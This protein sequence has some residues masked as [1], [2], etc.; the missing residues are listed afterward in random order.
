MKDCTHCNCSSNMQP[1][2]IQHSRLMDTA[3]ADDVFHCRLAPQTQKL[4]YGFQQYNGSLLRRQPRAMHIAL[5]STDTLTPLAG[6]CQELHMQVSIA[7]RLTSFT[8]TA[9]K[10]H[11]R[12]LF[13]C[14][15]EDRQSVLCPHLGTSVH[16][17]VH[18][19]MWCRCCHL[20]QIILHQ[21]MQSS[22]ECRVPYW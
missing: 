5:T 16:K 19:I 22:S 2:S 18:C 6:Y 20:G 8:T 10:A 11:I 21:N 17:V 1:I 7:N 9:E 12:H 4:Y 13:C 14:F 15:C 3:Y